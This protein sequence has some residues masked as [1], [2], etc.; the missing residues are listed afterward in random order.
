MRARQFVPYLLVTAL[1]LLAIVA[2]A[3][4]SAHGSLPSSSHRAKAVA[5]VTPAAGTYKLPAGT[6][7]SVSTTRLNIGQQFTITGNNCPPSEPVQAPFLGGDAYEREQVP[8]VRHTDGSWEATPT[9]PMGVWGAIELEA[10]CGAPPQQLFKYPQV[11]G[12]FISSPYTLAVSPSGP[13]APGT[14]VTVRPTVSFCSSLDTIAVGIATVPLPFSD[15]NSLWLVPWVV[16]QPD[17]STPPP[18]LS[19]PI[20]W[21]ASFAIPTVVKGGPY[22]V[23][24]A[25]FPGNRGYPG[26][27]ASS[28]IEV[29][30]SAPGQITPLSNKDLISPKGLPSGW[31]VAGAKRTPLPTCFAQ[32]LDTA[33]SVTAVKRT[34][35][36]PLGQTVA[37]E[38][39]ATY[40]DVSAAYTSITIAL[41]QCSEIEAPSSTHTVR[42]DPELPPTFLGSEGFVDETRSHYQALVVVRHGS[43]VIEV[44]VAD[45]GS[46][47]NALV[48]RLVARALQQAPS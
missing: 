6:T 9:V 47:D 13:L 10:T 38:Q 8:L 11:Y 5:P 41:G 7:F 26:I 18:S 20:S 16:A 3:L 15:A 43:V 21:H 4:S 17:D 31:E 35:I 44:A 48:H 12:A 2:A 36:R 46:P 19:A 39:I 23:A 34:L 28:E 25:C 30:S 24:A 32:A 27:Y 33:L 14:T 22:F 37:F 29:M 1:G 45:K 40:A 42:E